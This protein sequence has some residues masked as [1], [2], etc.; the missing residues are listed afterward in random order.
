MHH[1]ETISKLENN[2]FLWNYIKKSNVSD[3]IGI[4]SNDDRFLTVWSDRQDIEKGLGNYS[5]DLGMQALEL[6]ENLFNSFYPL[7]KEIFL[8]Y[9]TRTRG[10]YFILH[11]GYIFLSCT[12]GTYYILHPG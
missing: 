5:A 1:V 11:P 10:K 4:S 3:F 8:F 9:P 2:F 7:P 6:Y 12:R